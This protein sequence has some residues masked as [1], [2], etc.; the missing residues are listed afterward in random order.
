MSSPAAHLALRRGPTPPSNYALA[1]TSGGLAPSG[2]ADVGRRICRK[3]DHAAHGP[4]TQTNPRRPD[5]NLPSRTRAMR[6]RSANSKRALNFQRCA[7]L[8]IIQHKAPIVNP[9]PVCVT[10]LAASCTPPTPEPGDESCARLFQRRPTVGFTRAATAWQSP[11]TENYL[12]A[13]FPSASRPRSGVGCKPWL[14][15]SC[16]SFCAA[17]SYGP[18]GVGK[19]ERNVPGSASGRGSG[20]SNGRVLASGVANGDVKVVSPGSAIAPPPP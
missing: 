5:A 13:R 9:T 8:Y 7:L 2:A 19:G 4:P 3:D 12:K 17:A 18:T 11:S 16:C 20:D 14:G 10:G 6:G 15:G 1:G